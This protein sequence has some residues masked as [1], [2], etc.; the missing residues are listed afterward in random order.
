M[1]KR[2]GPKC[3]ARLRQREGTC[4]LPAGWGTDHKGHGRCRKHLGNTPNVAK[5]AETQRL[6]AEARAVLGQLEIEPCDD[7]LGALQA[8]VG[9]IL[10]WKDLWA[11][12]VAELT[13]V[14]YRTDSGEQLRAEIGLYERAL[15]RTERVLTAVARLDLDAR[16]LRLQEAQ[17]RMVNEII[18]GVLADLNLS[19]ELREAARPAIARRL[20]LAEAGERQPVQLALTAAPGEG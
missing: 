14:R 15:D 1:S 12:K 9:E 20:R 13:Q 17:A 11:R 16:L 8:V 2:G 4:D 6:E 19:A 3:G 10:A 5:A 18:R 7:W